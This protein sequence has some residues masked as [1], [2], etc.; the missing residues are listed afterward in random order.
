MKPS[1]LV[2]YCLSLLLALSFGPQSTDQEL[3]IREGQG[4]VARQAAN[5]KS[6]I[7]MVRLAALPAEIRAALLNRDQVTS[8]RHIPKIEVLSGDSL[9]FFIAPLANPLTYL[10]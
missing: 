5:K 3:L 6:L 2:K 4:I 10:H 8:S 1:G 9:L 7:V